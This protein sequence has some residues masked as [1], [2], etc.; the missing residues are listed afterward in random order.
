MSFRSPIPR[1]ARATVLLTL[2]AGCVAPAAPS[3]RP[4]VRFPTLRPGDERIAARRPAGTECFEYVAFGADDTSRRVLGP[5]AVEWGK[6]ETDAGRKAWVRS[7]YARHT[8]DTL[9]YDAT[10]LAPS[11]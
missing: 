6:G 10:S 3:P 11:R 1:L 7:A 5:L 4:G 8:E 2:A 9:D